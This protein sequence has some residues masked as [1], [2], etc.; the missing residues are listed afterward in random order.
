MP[1]IVNAVLLRANEVLLARRS[2]TR[3]AY[4]GLWSFPGGHVEAGESLDQA[5]H[6]ELQEEVGI[7]PTAFCRV[8]QIADPASATTIYHMYAVT[9]WTGAPAIRD[10]EHSE[11]RWFTLS[12][13]MLVGDLALPDYRA[14]FAELAAESP[15]LAPS[16]IRG[17]PRP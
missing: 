17:I 6:R 9:A 14:L 4:A 2:P 12:A 16:A 5:L 8:T 7:S 3:K 15:A 1:D 13:A 11:L 10:H